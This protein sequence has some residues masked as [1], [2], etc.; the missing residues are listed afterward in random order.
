MNLDDLTLGQARELARMFGTATPSSPPLGSDRIGKVVLVRSR[1]SGVW[2]GRLVARSEG[3]AG[4]S[5]ELADARRFWSWSGAGE[6]SSLALTGPSDGKIGPPSNP[7]VRE[8]LEDF[9]CSDA[10]IAAVAA[11]KVWT[12]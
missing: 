8:V 9:V 11:I 5:V 1:G 2:M 6:C 10:A 12:R 7:I 3:A 4:H